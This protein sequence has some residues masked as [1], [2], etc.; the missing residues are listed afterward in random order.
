M[1]KKSNNKVDIKE[2]DRLETRDDDGPSDAPVLKLYLGEP[3]DGEPQD[4]IDLQA[5]M[6]R[7]EA[8]EFW[9]GRNLAARRSAR[10]APSTPPSNSCPC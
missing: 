6:N 1:S 9:A 8:E 3:E 7:E 5:H 10:S 4:V 2:E